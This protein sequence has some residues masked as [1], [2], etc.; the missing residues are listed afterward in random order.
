[1]DDLILIWFC[2]FFRENGLIFGVV[3]FLRAN[4]PILSPHGLISYQN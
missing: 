4:E 3:A 2:N 1:M